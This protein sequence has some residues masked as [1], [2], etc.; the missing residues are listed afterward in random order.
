[1]PCSVINN[2]SYGYGK[3]EVVA[4]QKVK[5]YKYVM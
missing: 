1:M 3:Q 2:A 4:F 5:G